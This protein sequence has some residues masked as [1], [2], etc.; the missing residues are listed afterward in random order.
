MA[1]PL[2]YQVHAS[3]VPRDASTG[4]APGGLKPP[5]DTTGVTQRLSTSST[6]QTVFYCTPDTQVQQV[7]CLDQ[8]TRTVYT[9]QP[10]EPTP[11]IGVVIAKSSPTTAVVVAYGP[12]QGFMNL[13]PGSRYFLIADGLLTPPPVW[14]EMAPYVHPVG[15]AIL[16]D[17][18]FVM[19]QWPQV[20]RHMEQ[21]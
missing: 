20:K 4:V 3:G 17:T 14:A 2:R 5:R 1:L 10:T 9:A 13:I 15:Q 16:E 19:P 18:L 6:L 12:A 8:A 7:V 21:T 11:V